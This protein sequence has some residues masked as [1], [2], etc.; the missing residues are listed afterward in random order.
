MIRMLE[1]EKMR[2]LTAHI[3]LSLMTILYFNVFVIISIACTLG[4]PDSTCS[5]CARSSLLEAVV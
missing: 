5:E 2:Q 3:G 1:R 4:Q